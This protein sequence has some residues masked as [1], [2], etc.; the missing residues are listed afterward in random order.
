VLVDRR[1]VFMARLKEENIGTG[2]HFEALHCTTLYR[3]D[4]PKLPHTE[5]VCNRIL[6][7]PLYPDMT[8]R[9]TEDVVETVRSLLP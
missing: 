8:E 6:S 2:L 5:D 3:K 4:S 9:D 7:L 1:D